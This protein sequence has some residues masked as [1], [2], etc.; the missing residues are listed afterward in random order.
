MKI[1]KKYLLVSTIIIL[2]PIVFG[3]VMYDKLPETVAIHYDING[4]ADGFTKNI[5]FILGVPLFLFVIHIFSIFVTI[6]DP[7]H[8]NIPTKIYGLVYWIVPV[9]S[10]ST[11]FMLYSKI[12][13]DKIDIVKFMNFFT[14]IIFL[15]VGNYL[16]KC[17]QNYTIGIK[18]PWTLA[19]EDNWNKTHDFAGKLWVICSIILILINIFYAN[20]IIPL[21]ILSIMIFIPIIYSYVIYI[22]TKV[23]H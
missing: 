23:T 16:P 4:V 8:K 6:N 10:S 17:R 9:I 3:L 2:L 20:Y 18:L 7:K 19:N 14:G 11:M 1:N 22:K 13:T 5:Y 12:L 15:L 21:I